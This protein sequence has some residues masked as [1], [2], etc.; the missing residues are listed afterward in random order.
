MTYPPDIASH[1]RQ[2]DFFRLR[3]SVLPTRLSSGGLGRGLPRP[4]CIRSGEGTG[5]H[6][7]YQEEGAY[8]RLLP[9]AG[10]IS[11]TL[12]RSFGEVQQDLFLSC[13]TIG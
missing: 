9:K 12:D 8:E 2:E 10:A 4:I 6:G 11:G 3:P 13:L 1:S 5:N 7:S